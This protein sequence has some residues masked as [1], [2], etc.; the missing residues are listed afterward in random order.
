MRIVHQIGDARE[1]PLTVSPRVST[2]R[3]VVEKLDA[4]LPRLQ[5]PDMTPH[6]DL[7][8][9]IVIQIRNGGRRVGAAHVTLPEVARMSPVLE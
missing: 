4:V 3:K 2:A 8:V 6:D 9:S 7:G 1:R 5:R